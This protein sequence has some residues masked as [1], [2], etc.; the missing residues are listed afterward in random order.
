VGEGGGWVRKRG[1]R[2]RGEREYKHTSLFLQGRLVQCSK[3]GMGRNAKVM[4]V[5]D[6]S[7]LSQQQ[8]CDG[9][10]S[11]TYHHVWWHRAAG[12]CNTTECSCSASSILQANATL[13]YAGDS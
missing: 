4:C 8:G 11:I 12:L 7:L 10:G 6:V 1:G 2:G 13:L 3:M 5:R 9:I